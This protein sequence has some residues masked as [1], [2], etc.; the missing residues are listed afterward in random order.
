MKVLLTVECL[1][2]LR[3]WID[4]DNELKLHIAGIQQKC[5]EFE[6]QLVPKIKEAGKAYTTISQNEFQTAGDTFVDINSIFSFLR[7]LMTAI[8]D[9]VPQ[10]LD[11]QYFI[12][13][14]VSFRTGTMQ[15]DPTKLTYANSNHPFTSPVIA[16][17]IGHLPVE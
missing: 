7:R 10:G 15:L 8:C 11:W 2:R 5:A 1:F 16:G 14:E 9:R 3:K 12:S 17:D 6:Y 4:R 13:T